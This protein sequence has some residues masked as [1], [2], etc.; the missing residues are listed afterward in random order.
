MQAIQ[1]RTPLTCDSYDDAMPQCVS[2]L[3]H[4]L[5]DVRVTFVSECQRC[6]GCIIVDTKYG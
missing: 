1:T 5:L 2:I 6:H 3:G 4:R